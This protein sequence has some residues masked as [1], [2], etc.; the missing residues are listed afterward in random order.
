M[1]G[2]LKVASDNA[3]AVQNMAKLRDAVAPG[4]PWVY[5]TIL[6]LAEGVPTDVR[7]VAGHQAASLYPAGTQ[8]WADAIGNAAAD[9]AAN[10]GTQRH[11]TDMVQVKVMHDLAVVAS[12][13]V[14]IRAAV[15]DK[16]GSMGKFSQYLRAPAADALPSVLHPRHRWVRE[17]GARYRCLACTKVI[18]SS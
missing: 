3:A 13:A 2:P 18:T 12:A 7:K 8:A 6:Q 10:L 17:E 14:R 1:H 16:W 9:A 4:K 5:A 15:W 11:T